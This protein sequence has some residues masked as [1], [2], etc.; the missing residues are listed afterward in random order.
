VDDIDL[1]VGT[2]RYKS[3][4]SGGTHNGMRNIVAQ[5]G[6]DFPRLRIGI[7]KPEDIPLVD[8]VL[9]KIPK[10]EKQIFEEVAEEAID[11]IAEK[12]GVQDV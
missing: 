4:G 12:L 6:A 1:P 7:G 10:Q 8:F 2:Y 5:I 3:G 11:L 9:K